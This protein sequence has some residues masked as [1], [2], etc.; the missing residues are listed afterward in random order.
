MHETPS[1]AWQFTSSGRCLRLVSD[2][3]LDADVVRVR[4]A[5][6]YRV[7][8]R[9]RA[10]RLTPAD[11]GAN[12]WETLTAAAT[13]QPL[14]QGAVRYRPA[15]RDR[16]AS[17]EAVLYDFDRVPP[18]DEAVVARALRRVLATADAH[19]LGALAIP[20][21]FG[22]SHDGI[23]EDRWLQ[24]LIGELGR[25]AG[26]DADGAGPGTP[27]A[28]AGRCRNVSVLVD[29]RQLQRVGLTLGVL[30]GNAAAPMR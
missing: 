16:A 24:I 14:A 22:L 21:D 17:L 13:Y 1:C 7:L 19:A 26:N 20:Y 23:A 5:D 8:H 6:T 15:R 27:T 12:P 9:A 30:M 11:A 29:G 10:P 28:P 4:V 2:D 18:V 25:A 3:V